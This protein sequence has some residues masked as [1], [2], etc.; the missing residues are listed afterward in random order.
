MTT[1][2]PRAAKPDPAELLIRLRRIVT[3]LLVIGVI[4]GAVWF[5]ITFAAYM[6]RILLSAFLL[7]L[8]W[9]LV[10]SVVDFFRSP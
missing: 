3:T 4:G 7:V 6:G 8:L 1:T 5:A 2:T 9:V 10:V